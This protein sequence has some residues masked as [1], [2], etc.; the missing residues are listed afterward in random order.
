[1]FNSPS[2]DLSY[3]KRIIQQNTRNTKKN[4]REKRVEEISCT[5]S[6]KSF[7]LMRTVLDTDEAN[8][9]R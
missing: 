1:M 9:G 3:E 2:R 6:R 5:I 4:K 8:E 7:K